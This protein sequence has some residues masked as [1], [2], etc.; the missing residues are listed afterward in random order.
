VS[1]ALSPAHR[2]IVQDILCAH[3]PPGFAVRVFG[4]RA[5]GATK[6]FS[7]LDLAV[8]GGEAL[9][10][11]QLADLSEAFSQSDLPFKVD[12][13]DW[14]SVS[15]AFQAIIDRDGVSLDP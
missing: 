12:I 14:R 10:L 6:P 15:P 1:L 7:D 2:K 9:T 4:S 3:L 11:S 5:K 13:V 8:M